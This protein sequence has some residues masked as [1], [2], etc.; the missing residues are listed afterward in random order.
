VLSCPQCALIN[1]VPEIGKDDTRSVL[2]QWWACLVDSYLLLYK[3]YGDT[4][5]GARSRQ[6][7][8]V[9]KVW[10]RTGL[11]P[12]TAVSGQSELL[13]SRAQQPRS[14]LLSS[15]CAYDTL[16]CT[17]NVKSC[18]DVHGRCRIGAS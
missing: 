17:H 15:L 7:C 9:R 12:G 14:F 10:G 5:G 11:C 13:L 3:K 6:P 2:R 4:V 8:C 16:L 18:V 1:E